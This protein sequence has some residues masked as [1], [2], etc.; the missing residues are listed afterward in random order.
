M[1]KNKKPGEEIKI[2][3]SMGKIAKTPPMKTPPIKKKTKTKTKTSKGK[4]C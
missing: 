3:L 1:K 4:K 2:E